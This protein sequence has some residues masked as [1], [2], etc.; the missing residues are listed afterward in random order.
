MI[1]VKA[2]C[3]YCNGVGYAP[4]GKYDTLCTHCNGKGILTLTVDDWDIELEQK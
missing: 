3:K 4:D 2:I 1:R